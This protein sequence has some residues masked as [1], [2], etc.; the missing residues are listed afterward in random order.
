MRRRTFGSDLTMNLARV[1][2]SGD[3]PR[4]LFAT[5][6]MIE[7]EN[8]AQDYACMLNDVFSYQKEI[9]FEGE[10]HNCVLVVQNFLGIEPAAGGARGQRPHDVADAAVRAHRRH[11][12]CRYVADSFGLDDDDRSTLDAWVV[13]LQDWMAGILDWHHITRRYDEDELAELNAVGTIV[14]GGRPRA[15]GSIPSGPTGIGSVPSRL[16]VPTI[17]ASGAPLGR[18]C[19]I[20]SARRQDLHGSSQRRA[21]AG[22]AGRA[23]GHHRH[24]RGDRRPFR[25]EPR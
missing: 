2:Q 15:L 20:A 16:P 21:A 5:T 6:P 25:R 23:R 12:S 10:L 18:C 13:S 8:A 24:D 11:A 19:S 22:R 9:Q 17:P 1:T 4:E 7:L 3:L 14:A